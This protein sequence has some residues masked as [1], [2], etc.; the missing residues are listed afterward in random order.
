VN[1]WWC[2]VLAA[3]GGWGGPIRRPARAT[4][5]IGKSPDGRQGGCRGEVLRADDAQQV[6]LVALSVPGRGNADEG[7]VG[8]AAN[9]HVAQEVEHA[10]VGVDDPPVVGA[11][12]GDFVLGVQL[13]DSSLAA[14]GAPPA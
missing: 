10:D 11:T 1:G 12:H 5:W 9:K 8:L 3:D 2:A 7:L 4:R 6:E 14:V 13:C